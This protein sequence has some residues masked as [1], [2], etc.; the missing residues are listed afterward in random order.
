MLLISLLFLFS[1]SLDAYF[2]GLFPWSSL[3]PLARRPSLLCVVGRRRWADSINIAKVTLLRVAPLA[4]LT[5]LRVPS[6][7][8]LHGVLMAKFLPADFAFV[9]FVVR[10]RHSVVAQYSLLGKFSAA[11]VALVYFFL[12]VPLDVTVKKNLDRERFPAQFAL[13]GFL[14]DVLEYVVCFQC[15]LLR[16]SLPAQVTL[17]VSL[18]S[19]REG[20]LL[21]CSVLGKLLSTN[22]ALVLSLLVDKRVFRQRTPLGKSLTAHFTLEI[23]L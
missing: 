3:L 21:K 19:V 18:T 20:V 2:W 10:M 17:E 6:D 23:P 9:V 7:V 15:A 14:P 8:A 4:F 5:F 16:E 13:V 11:D 12:A 22:L 1:E